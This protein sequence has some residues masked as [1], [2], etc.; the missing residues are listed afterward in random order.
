MLSA[1]YNGILCID[2]PQGYTSF[3]VIA[4]LR[5]MLRMKKLGHSGT[6]DPLA[7][8]V[9]VVFAGNA[10]KAIDV[11]PDRDKAYHACF[12]LGYTSDTL[13]ITGR[14]DPVEGA[15]PDAVTLLKAADSFTGD[16]M[17]TPPMFSAVSVGG[18]RLYELARKGLCIERPERTVTI[19][20]LLVTAYDP[21][22]GEGEMDV[23][24]SSGT[25]I[26]T[27]IDDIG[28]AAGSGAIMTALRRTRS[29]YFTAEQ[30][31]TFEQVQKACDE[32]RAAE[33]FRSVADVFDYPCVRLDERL[34]KLFRNGV[35][36]TFGQ[37]GMDADP[38][39]EHD[40]LRVIGSSGEL[41]AI[42]CRSPKDE[43]VSKKN[44]FSN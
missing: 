9:L 15:L 14:I 2:K 12:K 25:Y 31:Y 39:G 29:S 11:I 23:V 16:I 19:R 27:L 43:L 35:K 34:T 21:V 42:G 36:L 30:C 5:G 32:G 7:T 24:C 13:D 28:R 41:L 4:K 22:T 40:Y 3:D 20:S 1:P 6:L 33:L 26:R 17:Q 44:L 37:Q 8:G 38:F 18:K 10:T